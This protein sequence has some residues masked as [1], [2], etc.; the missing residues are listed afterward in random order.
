T[1]LKISNANTDVTS[2][3][4]DQRVFPIFPKKGYRYQIDVLI[5]TVDS[6]PAD[7]AKGK[8]NNVDITWFKSEKE[9]VD[10]AWMK[11]DILWKYG[12]WAK[13]NRVPLLCGE[14]GTSNFIKNDYRVAWT[15]DIASVLNELGI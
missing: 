1:A 10:K 6:K 9:I 13:Q 12:N 2:I 11:K 14:F 15:A 7:P 3:S 8:F 5:R 4:F